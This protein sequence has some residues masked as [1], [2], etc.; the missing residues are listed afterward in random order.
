MMFC[1]SSKNCNEH[2]ISSAICFI[3]IFTPEILI[4][5]SKSQSPRYMNNHDINSPEVLPQLNL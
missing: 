1:E 5:T 2:F 4:N 3:Y